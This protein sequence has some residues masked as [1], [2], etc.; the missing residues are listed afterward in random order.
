M[1]KITKETLLEKSFD[2]IKDI[3]IKTGVLYRL[4][5]L[6]K[7][8]KKT[9]SVLTEKN[10]FGK[11]GIKDLEAYIDNY[12]ITEKN[13]N[14]ILS[15]I[16]FD[17]VNK[18]NVKELYDENVNFI[19]ENLDILF[20]T[21]FFEECLETDNGDYFRQLIQDSLLNLSSE[22]TSLAN[23]KP[24]EREMFFQDM[25]RS[26][27]QVLSR[28]IVMQSKIGRIHSVRE[29][30]LLKKNE[31][32]EIMQSLNNHVV[33]LKETYKK[34][35]LKEHLKSFFKSKKAQDEESDQDLD[36][37]IESIENVLYATMEIVLNII[38]LNTMLEK[39]EKLI[40]YENNIELSKKVF[41]YVV[42]LSKN[43]IERINIEMSGG[44][45]DAI[46]KK[47]EMFVRNL[48]IGNILKM[49][50]KLTVTE[51]N[52]LLKIMD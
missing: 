5:S 14:A 52:E 16:H 11:N 36:L 20:R 43:I 38:L 24:Y 7:K 19:S 34:K 17:E 41:S 31:N 8:D 25:A 29:N 51:V 49:Q 2:E 32:L 18:A 45:L 40:S 44:S 46:N 9:D 6:L 48:Y 21:K 42:S 10:L 27:I 50:K 30:Y 12:K 1:E 13:Q 28:Y 47:D 22:A 35:P 26:K 37:T 23:I 33:D 15:V 3:H 39:S 4:E